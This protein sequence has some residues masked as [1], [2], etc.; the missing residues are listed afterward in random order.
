ML[1]LTSVGGF[2]FGGGDVQPSVGFGYNMMEQHGGLPQSTVT[3]WL[4]GLPNSENE[5]LKLPSGNT[6]RVS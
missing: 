2:V 5:C 6:Y 3:D 1:P 4:E